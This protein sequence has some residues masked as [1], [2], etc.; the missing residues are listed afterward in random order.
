MFGEVLCASRFNAVLRSQ[1][2]LIGGICNLS[3]DFEPKNCNAEALNYV[4][5]L[6][7]M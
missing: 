2:V 4:C 1:S 5:L 6:Y 3:F 7:F